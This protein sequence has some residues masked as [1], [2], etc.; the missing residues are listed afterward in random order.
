MSKGMNN[1]VISKIFEVENDKELLNYVTYDKVPIWMISRYH[2]LYRLAGGK[3]LGYESE[4]RNRKFSAKI[5][6]NIMRTAVYNLTHKSITKDKTI[7]LYTTNRKTLVDKKYFNR[8]V[9]QLYDIYPEDS[10]VFEQPLLDWDWPF[11]RI[12]NTV[13]FDTIGRIKGEIFSRLSYKRDYNEVYKM[14]KYFNARLIQIC[15]MGLDKE[16][17][18]LHTNYIARLIVSMRYQSLWLERKLT[19]KTKVVVMVGAG[20]PFYYF[21]NRMLKEKEIISVELQHGYISKN[22]F[23][24]NYAEKIVHD[25]RV[26]QGLPEYMLTYGSWWN[27][28]M[29]CPIVKVPIGNPYREYCRNRIR[30]K[31]SYNRSIT[32]IGTT[33]ENINSYFE[34]IEYLGFTNYKIKFRPHPGDLDKA[35]RKVKENKSKI[36]IDDN[37]EIYETLSNTSILIGEVSTV[38]FEAIGIVNKILV[39]Q[40]KYTNAYL[41][42]HPFESF[43]S[44]K[45]LKEILLI[46]KK[47]DY[48]VD[49]FWEKN[50]KESYQRF[51]K[52]TGVKNEYK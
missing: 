30:K 34:L 12:N 46:N 11:P 26:Q 37:P 10:V 17:I 44:Y 9:D 28:Q 3:L 2:L 52:S 42:D 13:Y 8:Y 19:S 49:D 32:V 36:E 29:N 38:L 4:N 48:S 45:Q 20:F 14:I 25:K 51:I 6:K 33:G 5:I 40:T 43:S 15:G 41:P 16:E 27:G 23:M 1:N 35:K 18:K 22:N 39:W 47:V 31:N 50:W 21:L 7:Y 24:Y